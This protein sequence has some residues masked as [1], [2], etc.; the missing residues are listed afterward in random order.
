MEII[1]NKYILKGS[2]KIF[3]NYTLLCDKT[4]L[5]TKDFFRFNGDY[6]YLYPKEKKIIQ[7]IFI[8]I[9]IKYM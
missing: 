2:F 5:T 8:L 3:K 6:F 7:I 9:M 1:F 4:I